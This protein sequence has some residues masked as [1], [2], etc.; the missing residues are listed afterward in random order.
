MSTPNFPH[1]GIRV[2]VN[3]HG[4]TV[5]RLHY[6]ADPEK[7]E[8]EKTYVREIDRE[9]SPWALQQY[10]QMTDPNLY[11]Q[12]YEID[13][14]ATLGR[15]IFNFDEEASC[16][17]SFAIDPRWTRR[18]ALDPHPSVPHAFL[19]VAT[20][21]WGDRWYYR[22]FWPSKVCYRFDNGRLAGKPG[23]CPDDE[24]VIRIRDYVEVLRYLESAE[25]PANVWKGQAFKEQIYARVIDYAARAFGKGSSDDPE[26]PNFQERFEQHMAMP[27]IGVESCPYFEDAKKDHDVGF[28]MCNAGLKPFLIEGANGRM[29]KTARIH[30]FSDKC[31]ELIY[32][33]KNVRRQVLTPVQAATKDPTGKAV[34]VRCHLADDFRYLEMSDPR[35]IDPDDRG[36]SDWKPRTPGI[37]Y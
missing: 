11:L 15:R 14:E 7:A 1:P 27:D 26:Q 17:P 33:L 30:I 3:S 4:I 25:N 13:A 12:E 32:E 10:R 2:H 31:P 22:E 19:W 34:E 9:L 8:G 29:R 36:V 23:P 20:D 18:N 28:E 35:F 5:A 37:A 6:S 16:E 21:P 24:P